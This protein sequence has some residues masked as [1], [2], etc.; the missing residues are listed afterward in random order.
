MTLGHIT[1][2]SPLLGGG[3]KENPVL[4]GIIGSWVLELF[5]V[6]IELQDLKTLVKYQFLHQDP[7]KT[8]MAWASTGQ[9]SITVL[10]LMALHLCGVVGAGWPAWKRHYSFSPFGVQIMQKVSFAF[11]EVVFWKS[12]FLLWQ[13]LEIFSPKSISSSCDLGR[14]S[15][16]T[17]IR[18]PQICPLFFLLSWLG[19]PFILPLFT[20]DTHLA[21]AFM[22][23]LH[24]Q[25]PGLLLPLA[26]LPTQYKVT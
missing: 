18:G 22:W 25:Y 2:L 11:S 6:L 10:L 1:C 8:V 17:D 21:L 7:S 3:G 9:F 26:A 5:F 14:V 23:L 15:Y 4:P 24:F 13:K 16:P 19:P 12:M 20:R